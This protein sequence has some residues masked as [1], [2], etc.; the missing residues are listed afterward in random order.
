MSLCKLLLTESE[1]NSGGGKKSGTE[2]GVEGTAEVRFP[3][4]ETE[5]VTSSE[6]TSPLVDFS[7][8]SRF[9]L[10]SAPG[11]PQLLFQHY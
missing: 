10:H 6:K 5:T 7:F 4:S 8:F 11:K 9:V 2:V 3:E 1:A